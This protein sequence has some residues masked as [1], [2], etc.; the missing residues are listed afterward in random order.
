DV[1]SPSQDERSKTLEVT[2]A[3]LV[4]EN[5]NEVLLNLHALGSSHTD[6]HLCDFL[7]NH[8]L[9]DEVKLIKKMGNHLTNLCRL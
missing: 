7:E 5:L 2:E 4:L 1:Q 9:D 6:H 8:F 3:A